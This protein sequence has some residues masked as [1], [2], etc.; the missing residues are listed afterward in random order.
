MVL[1]VSTSGFTRDF[2]SRSPLHLFLSEKRSSLTFSISTQVGVMHCGIDV[3]KTTHVAIQVT[4]SPACLFAHSLTH[5]AR[6]LVRSL[7]H[8]LCRSLTRSCI[9]INRFLPK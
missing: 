3:S 5:T 8:S 2:S 7:A 6:V 1:H 4:R 9:D